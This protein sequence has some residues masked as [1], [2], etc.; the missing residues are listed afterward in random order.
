ME[1]L[2]FL[3]FFLPSKKARLFSRDYNFLIANFLLPRLSHMLCKFDRQAKIKAIFFKEKEL[4]WYKLPTLKNAGITKVYTANVYRALRGV[5]R[6]FLHYLWKRAVRIT[7]NPYT[8]R[9]NRLRD[10]LGKFI[11]LHKARYIYIRMSTMHCKY[12]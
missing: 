2:Q 8:Q 4:C 10:S 12:L 11:A 3:H 7:E 9:E 1:S 5:C 6:F